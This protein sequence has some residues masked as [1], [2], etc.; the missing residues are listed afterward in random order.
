MEEGRDLRRGQR[1]EFSSAGVFRSGNGFRN[2]NTG[3]NYTVVI[4][5]AVGD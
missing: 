5:A 1:W 2:G 4:R 3:C